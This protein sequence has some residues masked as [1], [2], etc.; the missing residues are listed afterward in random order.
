MGSSRRVTDWGIFCPVVDSPSDN[1]N[2]PV[3]NFTC[4]PGDVLLSLVPSGIRASRYRRN[5]TRYRSAREVKCA[6]VWTEVP[7][8]MP[9][10]P[11]L[12]DAT[13]AQIRVR[14]DRSGT[15]S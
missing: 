8:L 1:A 3:R 10:P 12:L 5:L 15:G 6:L 11:A 9:L 14:L 2:I 7:L 4:G 13:L